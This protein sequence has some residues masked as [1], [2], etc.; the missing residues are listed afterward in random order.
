MTV[1]DA[2]L[3]DP[4][5]EAAEVVGD[6]A[7]L[8]AMVDVEAAHLA[9]LVT[10]GAAAGTV[11]WDVQGIDLDAIARS[12]AAGGNPVIPLVAALRRMTP[13]PLDDAVHLGLTSQDVLDDA[14]ML[15]AGRAVDAAT[16][17]MAR[18]L[19]GLSSLADRERH[20]PVAGRTLG[21][22]A[23]PSTV[24]L[25]FAVLLDG[26]T[27]TWRQLRATELPLQLGGSVGTVA[28]LV[29]RLGVEG[30]EAVRVDVATR[31][32]LTPRIGVWHVERSPVAQLGTALAALIGALGRLGLEVAQAARTELGELELVLDA[33]EGGS[34]AMPQKQNPVPAVLLVANAR[35]APALASVLL[36]SQLALDDRPAG[37]WHA[38]WQPL[39]ELLRLAIE[40]T[41]LADRVVASIAVHADRAAS[42]L[43]LG[44]GAVHAERAQ[45]VLAAAI[46]RTRSAGLVRSA[47]GAQDF[48]TAVRAAAAT[49]PG[50]DAETLERLTHVTSIGGPV[51]LSDR[52]IDAAISAA[53]EEVR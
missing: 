24:G 5:T 23:A 8:A 32:G 11:D 36:G 3:L 14:F 2:G 38:E 52:L 46:G 10:A 31:L 28:V 20:T 33:G 48:A 21:Q 44:G 34:S 13:T 37:D 18:V 6:G 16:A 26:A 50:I 12:A 51:G 4:G 40:S 30:A 17:P 43:G 42:N 25:R 9:A 53:Q 19:T 47:L 39:R 7:L 49:E 15:L 45:Q 27:R 22:Q 35:R 29:D 41:V 1:F